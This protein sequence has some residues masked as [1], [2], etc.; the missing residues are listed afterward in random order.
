MTSPEF[1]KVLAENHI[2]LVSWRDLKKIELSPT[3]RIAEV[4]LTLPE[5]PLPPSVQQ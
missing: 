5:Q 3:T 4:D 2:I 1:K